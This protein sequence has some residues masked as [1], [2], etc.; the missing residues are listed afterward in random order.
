ME[1]KTNEGLLFFL[2]PTSLQLIL[3]FVTFTSSISSLLQLYKLSS[4]M[5]AL[6]LQTVSLV[7]LLIISW[8]GS[9]SVAA[10]QHLCGS[11]LVD[12]LYLVCGEK[13]FFYNSKRDVNPL[14]GFLPPKAGGAAATGGENEVAEFTFKD[15]MEMMGKR[16]PWEHCCH[17]PCTLS[18]LQTYCK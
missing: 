2:T 11:H 14:M 16:S 15:Q 5:A 18:D 17:T 13:G 10:E 12:A 4:S 3:L 7:V 9:H 6:W 8:P 1:Y